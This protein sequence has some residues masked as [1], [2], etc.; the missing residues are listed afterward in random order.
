MK[1]IFKRRGSRPDKPHRTRRSDPPYSWTRLRPTY[2]QVWA[3]GPKRPKGQGWRLI[4]D[5][6]TP[7]PYIGWDCDRHRFSLRA[8]RRSPAFLM[9][10]GWRRVAFPNSRLCAS[11]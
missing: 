7:G 5:G 11:A 2:G 9:R 8:W 4:F 3:M 1:R 10:L 6:R